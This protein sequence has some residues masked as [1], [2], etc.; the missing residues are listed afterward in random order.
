MKV[1]GYTRVSSDEQAK[2]GLGIAAQR[3]AILDE[4]ARRGWTLHSWACDEG[5][6]AKRGAPPRPAY[7]SARGLLRGGEADAL[8]SVKLD[9]VSRSTVDFGQLLESALL[10]GWDLVLMDLPADTTSASGRATLRLMAVMAEL[11]RDLISERTTAALAVLKA[12]GVVL[13][14]PRRIPVSTEALIVSYS[15]SLSLAAVADRLNREGVKSVGGKAWGKS[16]VAS[17]VRRNR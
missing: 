11:E 2:S 14:A 8:I 13:G 16:T 7:L 15:K 3:S 17:V 9:R 4:V 1:I 5:Y 6:S 12:R 10:E